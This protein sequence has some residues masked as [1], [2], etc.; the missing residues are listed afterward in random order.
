[1]LRI[2]CLIVI[3]EILRSW[4]ASVS[5]TRL[6]V[7][8]S[9]TRHRN[10]PGDSIGSMPKMKPTRSGRARRGSGFNGMWHVGTAI[11]HRI[12]A[13]HLIQSMRR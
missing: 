13:R 12:S 9:S 10:A 1:M 8:D 7:V 11:N 2:K 6:L 3:R 5:T 4:L